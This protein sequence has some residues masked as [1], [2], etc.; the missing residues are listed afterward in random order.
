MRRL[1]DL[2]ES[3]EQDLGGSDF[4]SESQRRL[5]RRAAMLTLQTELLDS[6]FASDEA[7]AS[8]VDLELYQ[9]L[10][11]TLRRLLE[12]LGLKRIPRDVSTPT[13]EQY[14][15]HLNKQQEAAQ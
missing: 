11:N 6:K 1:R 9:K 4:V 2:I 12:T 3:H 5:V 10:S 15:A 13:V 7:A 8:R 14:I